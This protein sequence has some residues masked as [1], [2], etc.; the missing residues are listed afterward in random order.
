ML[1]TRT[2]HVTPPARRVNSDWI[3]IKPA[4]VSGEIRNRVMPSRASASVTTITVA[5]AV[6][7]NAP[8]VITVVQSVGNFVSVK[9]TAHA[10]IKDDVYVNADGK[11]NFATSLVHPVIYFI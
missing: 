2:K 11:E 1:G 3:A 9:T 7:P 6:R 10:T 8:K 4:T 5:F